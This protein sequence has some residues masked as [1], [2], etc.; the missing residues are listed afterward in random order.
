MSYPRMIKCQ[1][2]KTTCIIADRNQ[3]LRN[4]RVCY[5]CLTHDLKE[6]CRLGDISHH[7]VLYKDR[8]GQ[9]RFA[10]H[11]RVARPRPVNLFL[12]QHK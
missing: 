6:K 4:N 11:A 10:E 2:A 9:P 5:N 1:K 7:N 8:K 3:F 12:H